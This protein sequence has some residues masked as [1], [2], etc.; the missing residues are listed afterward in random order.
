ML[1]R[2]RSRARPRTA[3]RSVLNRA[4]SRFLPHAIF[5][6]AADRRGVVA[7]MVALASPMLILAAGL[8]VD[9]G[10]WY[11]QEHR[12]Q[13]AADAGAMA[14]ARL[15]TNG[16]ATTGDY[17]A[18]AQVDAQGA[19]G[20]AP[21]GTPAWP[22]TVTVNGTSSVT[23]IVTSTANLF[24]TQSIPGFTVP[25]RAS[26]TA[27]IVQT[28]APCILATSQSADDALLVHDGGKIVATG[29]SVVSDSSSSSAIDVYA[30][31]QVSAELVGTAGG[32]QSTNGAHIS[33]APVSV[34]P[35]SDPLSGQPT[36]DTG[37]NP[38]PTPVCGNGVE[39]CTFTPGV[40]PNGISLA[41]GNK[42]VFQPGTYY[43]TGPAPGTTYD[44]T[45]Q[46]GTQIQP[47]N[48]VTF[49]ITDSAPAVNIGNGVKLSITAPTS[50]SSATP[51]PGL[52]V[53]IPGANQGAAFTID[54]G[55]QIVL[56]GVIYVPNA[57]FVMNNGTRIG[58]P[59]GG[60]SEL[61]AQTVAVYGGAE[62][63]AADNGGAGTPMITTVALLD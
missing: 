10:S 48:G 39:P 24:F 18:A 5:R 59:S 7:L 49:V 6:L 16:Q 58:P 40:Y 34:A 31:A 3:P 19:I 57:G 33:P 12:L 47:L 50:A 43:I 2:R 44:L 63:D 42:A 62:F 41:N 54:G 23:V 51:Y 46:G 1:E 13:L 14:A 17:Q 32:F 9:V 60:N 29:C 20:Q 8:A 53:Y 61:I 22:P 27:G 25:L 35:V 38:Q 37:A 15:L 45:L 21:I 11:M 4:G 55:G 28:V 52:A 36:P 26:A 30:G 56:N